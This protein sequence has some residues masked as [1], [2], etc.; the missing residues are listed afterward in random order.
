MIIPIPEAIS[1]DLR[2]IVLPAEIAIR[3]R[4]FSVAIAEETSVPTLLLDELSEDAAS[5]WPMPARIVDYIV[6]HVKKY[7]L[8]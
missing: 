2:L 3:S 1:A 8:C 6:S 7:D 4:R 5:R